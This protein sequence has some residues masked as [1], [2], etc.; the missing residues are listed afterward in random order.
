MYYTLNRP[1]NPI[2]LDASSP[3][4]GLLRFGIQSLQMAYTCAVHCMV[5]PSKHVY[6]HT[7]LDWDGGSQNDIIIICDTGAYGYSLSSNYNLRLRPTEI[8]IKSN[9]IN[10]I[11]NRQKI[12][13]II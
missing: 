5:Y 6:N 13:D 8:L 4:V 2:E 7:L 12:T 1:Q 11:R 9:K 10:I 3:V